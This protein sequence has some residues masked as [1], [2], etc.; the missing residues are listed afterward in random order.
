MTALAWVVAGIAVPLV[1]ALAIGGIIERAETAR[2]WHR[3][4][5]PPT[6]PLR[7]VRPT[8]GGGWDPTVTRLD[9]RPID[10]SNP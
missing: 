3:P 8:P 7:L 10:R 5:E 6:E 9:L 1:C 2:R 4:A